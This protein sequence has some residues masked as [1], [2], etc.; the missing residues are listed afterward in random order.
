MLNEYRKEL[1]QIDLEIAKLFNKRM[2][3]IEKVAKFKLL[4]NIDVED[5]KRETHLK[6]LV[7]VV[8]NEKYKHYF[9]E[10]HDNII[11]LS[12]KYQKS[13]LR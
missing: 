6:S 4:N 10:V 3:I 2:E 12:K 11:N 13:C 8:V 1:E 7:S 9:A 5:R